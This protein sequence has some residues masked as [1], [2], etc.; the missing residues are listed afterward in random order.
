MSSTRLVPVTALAAAL[1]TGLLALT[2]C[3]TGVWPAADQTAP[4]PLRLVASFYPLQWI[5]ERVAGADV[6]SLTKPGV[7]PHDLELTPRDVARVETA[8]LVVY[9][10][11]FQPAVDA[12]VAQEAGRHA[13]D[14]APAARLDLVLT[15]DHTERTGSAG[16]DAGRDPHFW[17]DPTRL[18]DVADAV[19]TR[20]AALRPDQAAGFRARASAVRAD[21]TAL[22]RDFRAGLAHC[23]S[24]EL[25]TSHAAFGYL[26]RRYGLTQVGITGLD[27]EAEPRPADLAR[28]TAYVRTHHIRTVYGETLASPAVAAALARETGARTAVLDPLE[29]LTDASRG[30]DYLSVMRANLRAL[31]E[32]QPCR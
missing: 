15:A 11:G 16:P 5:T 28:I 12:A 29:G 30:T 26:A 20:L 17:L 18:A 21:L 10:S 2:G 3:G 14:V 24:R 1:V 25:V 4:R 19:A 6:V 32:G 31:Q 7:E 8:D 13:L 27:P 23:A 22:D 9:L